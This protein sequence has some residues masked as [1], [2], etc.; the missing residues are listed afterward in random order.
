MSLE[1]C[2]LY[3]DDKDV[4]K[5]VSILAKKGYYKEGLINVYIERVHTSFGSATIVT[6]PLKT[7]EKNKVAEIAIIMT[8]K[9]TK[10][11]AIELLRNNKNITRKIYY[12]S[13]G[14]V[15]YETLDNQNFWNC[16]YRC[17]VG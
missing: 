4:K 11:Y 15:K 13:K 10:T 17:V 2:H 9:G 12:D 7:Y 14:T 16:L 6:I 5:H 8:K 3:I 1:R